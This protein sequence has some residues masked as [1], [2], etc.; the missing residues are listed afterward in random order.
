MSSATT[1]GVSGSSARPF[2][3]AAGHAIRVSRGVRHYRRPNTVVVCTAMPNNQPSKSNGSA[4]SKLQQLITPFS[5]PAASKKM[6]AL[7]TG[8]TY[9][10]TS[11][12]EY[13]F[14]ISA[15][16]NEDSF[17]V[18]FTHNFFPVCGV[19]VGRWL[20]LKCSVPWRL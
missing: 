15:C 4:V 16:R 13:T 5:D 6:L 20:Q 7:A 18:I 11:L 19:G 2:R 12:C 1:C 3:V 17:N 9:L 14:R 8:R 10:I